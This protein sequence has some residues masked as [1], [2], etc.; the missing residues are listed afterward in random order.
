M[1]EI[2]KLDEISQKLDI[3][4]DKLGACPAGPKGRFLRGQALHKKIVSLTEMGY[5]KRQIAEMLNVSMATVANARKRAKE[6]ASQPLIEA[7]FE[8]IEINRF[9]DE[10]LER[11][12]QEFR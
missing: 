1:N 4:L 10:E 11:M 12:L 5:S 3:I 2:K 9:D 8:D 6:V 7:D